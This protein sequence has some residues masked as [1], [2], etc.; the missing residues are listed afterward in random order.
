[1]RY[2]IVLKNDRLKVNGTNRDLF[3]GA[4]AILE[5]LLSDAPIGVRAVVFATLVN[6]VFTPEEIDMAADMLE[7][8]RG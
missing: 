5:R 3:T 4:C 8:L 6:E 1:M 2:S 7:D